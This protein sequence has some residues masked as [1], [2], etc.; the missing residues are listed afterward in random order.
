M[1]HLSWFIRYFLC[2]L[3][4]VVCNK[5]VINALVDLKSTTHSVIDLSQSTTR[6]L[7]RLFINLPGFYHRTLTVPSYHR[8]YPHKYKNVFSAKVKITPS[9][10]PKKYTN[11]ERNCLNSAVYN[12]ET[13]GI[14]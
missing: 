8:I 11:K 5:C 6:F 2:T 13:N 14:L 12:R 7:R 9:K 3:T 4:L 1:F 10:M